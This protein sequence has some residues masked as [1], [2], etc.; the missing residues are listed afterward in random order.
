ML[1]IIS[2][3]DIYM[4]IKSRNGPWPG[5][6]GKVLTHTPKGGRLDPWPERIPIDV[7]L[8]QN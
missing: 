4:K 3:I 6:L 1:T 7:S 8:S 2:E 5:S